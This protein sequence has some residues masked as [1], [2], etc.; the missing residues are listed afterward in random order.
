MLRKAGSYGIIYKEHNL[1]LV[2]YT[3]TQFDWSSKK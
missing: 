1:K 3:I 2:K